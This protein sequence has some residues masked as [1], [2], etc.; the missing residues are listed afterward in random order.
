MDEISDALSNY[1]VNQIEVVNIKH[2]DNDYSEENFSKSK[3]KDRKVTL[4]VGT[5]DLPPTHEKYYRFQGTPIIQLDGKN[6]G[7]FS[8]ESPKFPPGT[9]FEATLSPDKGGRSVMLKVDRESIRLPEIQL[10]AMDSPEVSQSSD[11]AKTG[12]RS[13]AQ[14]DSTSQ[15]PKLPQEWASKLETA[16]NNGKR[17]TTN[18]KADNWRLS[19]QDTLFSVVSE[20]YKQRRSHLPSDSTQHFKFGDNQ[21][22]AYVQPNG[23]C[24]VRNESKRT[25]FKAN[26]HTGEV[27]IPLTEQAAARFQ[28]M[29]VERE[30]ALFQ[31]RTTFTPAPE[32]KPRELEMV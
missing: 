30:K 26:V 23:D 11:L 12:R 19:L 13:I 4:Q 16:V 32:S 9:T 22:T 2:P 29:I 24:F 18:A 1:Q 31:S 8:P 25:V 10:P 21:W 20:T 5:I 28:E 15:P 6:L 27:Q 17:D 3:W 7:T 14:N